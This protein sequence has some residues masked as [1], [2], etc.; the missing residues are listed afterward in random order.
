MGATT[1]LFAS[2]HY[3]AKAGEP[4]HP[5]ELASF[6]FVGSDVAEKLTMWRPRNI[7]DFPIPQRVRLATEPAT[8]AA[9][10]AGRGIG[11]LSISFAQAGL[12]AG[13]LV[14]V[15]PEWE[16][17][18]RAAMDKEIKAFPE[19]LRMRSSDRIIGP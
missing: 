1:G 17:I 19:S 3:L 14:R 16:V 6:L 2:P 7:G 12:Q 4:D 11:A 13:Q 10:V 8:M 18:D 15:L 5:R 9:V